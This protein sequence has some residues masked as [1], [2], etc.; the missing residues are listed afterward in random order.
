MKPRPLFENVS[1]HSQLLA[2]KESELI[3]VNK[4]LD[5]ENEAY[6]RA[7]EKFLMARDKYNNVP[8]IVSNNPTDEGP[9]RR[10]Q[11]VRRTPQWHSNYSM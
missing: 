11:R 6:R 5:E 9:L 2:E 7:T 10:S 1:R 3:I 4:L 8:P